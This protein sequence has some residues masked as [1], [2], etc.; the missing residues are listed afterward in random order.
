LFRIKVN[1]ITLLP[2]GTFSEEPS[3]EN[4]S[5]ACNMVARVVVNVFGVAV[6]CSELLYGIPRWLP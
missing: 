1:N 4:V 2:R 5:G 3:E 6:W